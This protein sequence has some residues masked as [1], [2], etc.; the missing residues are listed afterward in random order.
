MEAGSFCW[1]KPHNFIPFCHY[2][3]EIELP[4]TVLV[5]APC[6]RLG[7]QG[8][9]YVTH[10]ETPG[11]EL[12]NEILK[13]FPSTAK[14]LAPQCPNTRGFH[15]H[16][17]LSSQPTIC[18]AGRAAALQFLLTIAQQIFFAG[19]RAISIFV[20]PECVSGW[21]LQGCSCFN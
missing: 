18:W 15:L 13:P 7:L 10:R 5:R 6:C 20:H 9:C 12:Q 3:S 17:S 11:M 4:H 16:T 8:W 1:P 14:A 21:D 2:S 19:S